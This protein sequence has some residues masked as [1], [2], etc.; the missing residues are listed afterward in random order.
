MDIK[1]CKERKKKGKQKKFRRILIA[2]YLVQ[3]QKKKKRDTKLLLRAELEFFNY[4]GTSF[5]FSFS[6]FSFSLHFFLFS[7]LSKTTTNNASAAVNL[8]YSRLSL[9]GE[10]CR[11]H[12]FRN[13]LR[14]LYTAVTS[15]Q[16]Q[17]ILHPLFFFF[18]FFFLLRKHTIKDLTGE[19][20]NVLFLPSFDLFKFMFCIIFF[21]F[22]E[23]NVLYR[24]TFIL[25]IDVCV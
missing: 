22:F 4:E 18:L 3:R 13:V 8:D 24:I 12:F 6:S 5:L 25:S 9:L 10:N 14:D 15:I 7:F 11:V 1:N 21:F 17:S 2:T 20:I 19:T 16:P 23:N